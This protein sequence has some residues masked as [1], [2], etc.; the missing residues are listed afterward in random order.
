MIKRM[1]IV[2]L[3]LTLLFGGIFGWKYVQIQEM[4]AMGSVAPPPATISSETVLREQRTPGLEAVGS[5]VA[6]Q[7]VFISTQIPGQVRS[8]HFESGAMVAKGDD[9]IRLDDDVDRAEL[10]GLVAAQK[11]ARLQFDR[12]RK[13]F[14]D[15]TIS[16][17]DFDQAQA[18]L[19]GA[20]ALVVSQQARINKK[21]IRA[22]FAGQL[23]IRQV[24][25]G[26]Y[27]APGEPIVSLQASDPVYVDY[28]LP[29]RYLNDLS[30][31]QQVELSV[32]AYPG[33]LFSGSITAISP[34]IE[35]G[36]RSVQ[37]RATLKN[38]DYR[39]RS[40]MFAGV[41][42][43]LPVRDNVLSLSEM[44]ITY[45]PYG[46]FV[47][48]IAEKDGGLLVERRQVETGEVQAG[49][50]DII[51][52]LQEGDQVVRAG[53]NKLRNGMPVQIDNSVKLDGQI[54]SP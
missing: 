15:N 41:R 45:N 54:V 25:L 50:V 26:Q 30:I 3:G 14:S 17:S 13:L 34:R 32:Q 24:D 52:G 43:L 36:T 33:E 37:V 47:F 11:L 20:S 44:A 23:G 38:P 39:L 18:A 40:G 28:S 49:R 10:A 1:I 9:L 42:T 27:L 6:S 29:E 19:D 4:I 31:G 16:R 51:S 5:L 46:N 53:H 35:I 2:L 22:P 7:E 8:I 12:A 48:F 21:R